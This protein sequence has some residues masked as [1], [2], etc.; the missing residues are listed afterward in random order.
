MPEPIRYRVD[1]GDRVQHLV[2]VTVAIPDDVEEPRVA[3]ASW[4]PGSYT[5]RNYARHIQW[6]AACDARGDD[7]ELVPDGL[8]AWTV[9]AASGPVTIQWELY[10]NELTVR[11]NHVDDHH[12]LLIP[13]ATFLLVDGCRDRTHVVAFDEVEDPVW[14]L[15]T[16]GDEDDT[17][18]ADDFDHL[19]DSAFEVGDFPHVDYEVGGVPHRF[20]WAGHGPPPPLDR[21]AD[22]CAAIGEAAVRLL[23]GDLPTERYTLLCVGWDSAAGGGGLEHRDGAV[24]MFPVPQTREPDK[25]ARFQRLV[26]HEYLH[27]WN[28]K[29]LVP[30][31][32]TR[33]DLTQPTHTTSL[34]VAEG[35]TDFYDDLLAL[36]AGVWELERFLVSQM[37]LIEKVTRTPGAAY[38]SVRQASYEAWIKLYLRDE[39]TPNVGVNYYGH[40]ALLAW[41]LDL[42]IRAEDPDGPGL[43]GALR[44]LWS[45]FGGSPDGYTEPDVEAA[46]AEVAGRDLS[47][48]FERHVSGTELPP[49]E[50]LLDVVGLE[51]TEKDTDAPPPPDLGIETSDDERGVV[52]SHVLRDG[53]AWDA[54]LTGGDRLLAIDGLTVGAD[55]FDAVLRRYAEGDEVDATVSRGPRVLRL[56][57]QLGSPRPARQL[58]AV[59]DPSETQRTAFE[60]W[61]GHDL[62]DVPGPDGD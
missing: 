26:A 59:P 21:V 53:P 15:L 1:L 55:E 4:T 9:P 41:S 40:G 17:Y 50:D 35:W 24:L 37:E 39:N 11:T 10:A 49:I 33:P 44:L 52:I 51:I 20:V 6:I 34:W 28:V 27:L 8:G 48:F 18:V 31:A 29:R 5:I 54:G 57:V 36:R 47:D 25:Y 16:G 43:D 7:L 46:V 60:R 2:R 42:L 12:A 30:A 3:L 61:T 22:D 14:S 58:T 56:E 19:V 45:R 62:A 32:L 13:A 38:Q 23:D